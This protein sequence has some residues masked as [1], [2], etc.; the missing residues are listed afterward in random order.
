[1][2]WFCC[3]S[4][5]KDFVGSMVQKVQTSPNQSN[6]TIPFEQME[7]RQVAYYVTASTYFS[8]L[9]QHRSTYAPS[10]G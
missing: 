7:R 8:V 3:S 5:T 2:L 1:M 9:G 10:N 4:E 6:P